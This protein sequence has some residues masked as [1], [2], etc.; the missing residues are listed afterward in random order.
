MAH[1]HLYVEAV[2]MLELLLINI[3]Q[4]DKGRRGDNAWP[5]WGLVMRLIQAVSLASCLRIDL[6]PERW[7]CTG[8][9]TD[10]TYR[11]TSPRS[12][13]RCFGSVTRQTHSKPTASRGRKFEALP[14]LYCLL[15]V[16][17]AI[18]PEHCDTAFPAEALNHLGEKTY[19]RLR[20]ELSQLSSE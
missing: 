14:T 13:A 18:N 5:L 19:P 1:L 2:H 12:G 17:S 11:R 15:T 4:L 9:P 10:G 6:T 7:A 16:R 3:R 8:T 20:F